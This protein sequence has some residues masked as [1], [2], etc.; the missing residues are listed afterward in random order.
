MF[1]ESCNVEAVK[2]RSDFD[3]KAILA[4]NGLPRSKQLG[5][6]KVMEANSLSAL[7]IVEVF[8]RG[9][10]ALSLP[11]TFALHRRAVSVPFIGHDELIQ[12]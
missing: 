7:V 12:L 8:S 3:L 11:D 4:V 9:T 2:R 1:L 10:R 5:P 6:S